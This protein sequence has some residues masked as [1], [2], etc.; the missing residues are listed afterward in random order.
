MGGVGLQRRIGV[1]IRVCPV[2]NGG[3]TLSFEPSRFTTADARCHSNTTGSQ[4]RTTV[5]IPAPPVHNGGRPLSFKHHR[6]TTADARC[7]S[8]TT[9][10]QRWTTVVNQTSTRPNTYI[11]TSTN[12][13]T[14]RSTNKKTPPKTALK[15]SR[16]SSSALILLFYS[17]GIS[18]GF[19]IISTSSMFV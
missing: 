11:P 15:Q 1:V 8:S 5:V 17:S 6:F 19:S 4:R 14:I 13:S 10:S 16:G 7:H 12:Q 2:Y 9:G 3:R 18:R